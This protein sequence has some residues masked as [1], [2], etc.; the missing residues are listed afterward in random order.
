[1]IG[2]FDPVP[3]EFESITRIQDSLYEGNFDILDV[4]T[5]YLPTLAHT[6]VNLVEIRPFK[7]DEIA[8]YCVFFMDVAEFFNVL[9]EKSIEQCNVLV[10]KLFNMGCIS[11]SEL[12]HFLT[13]QKCIFPY[14][15]FTQQISCYDI[16]ANGAPDRKIF[17][18]YCSKEYL[19]E[20][21]DFG[22][23]NNSLEYIIKYDDVSGLLNKLSNPL[24]DEHLKWTPFEWSKKPSSLSMIVFAA[25]FGSIHCY[26]VLLMNGYKVSEH[27]LK[28]IVFSGCHDMLHLL[29]KN[30][31]DCQ[32]MITNAIEYCHP[33]IINWI[34]FS[35]DNWKSFFNINYS[36]SIAFVLS[37]NRGTNET[38]ISFNSLFHMAVKRG[39]ISLTQFLCQNGIDI[40]CLDEL[41][42]VCFR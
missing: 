14:I 29:N 10:Y 39:D 19:N 26:K 38:S 37:K 34:G 25:H 8:N 17:N 24:M 18:E 33:S 15:Y 40:N 4:D 28:S 30:T 21:K 2:F 42:Y 3:C 32:Y 23:P 36:R 12:F 1:M 7:L 6:L 11:V 5:V 9:V 41:I 16:L 27:V 20:L 22:F 35:F 13:K 31:F